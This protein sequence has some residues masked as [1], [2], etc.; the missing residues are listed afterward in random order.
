VYFF[1]T[2]EPVAKATTT[3][4]Q[5]RSARTVMAVDNTGAS[6]RGV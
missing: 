5:T 2:A 3:A 1:A 6:R 4:G